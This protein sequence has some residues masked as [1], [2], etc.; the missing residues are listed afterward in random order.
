M[1]LLRVLPFTLLSC[2]PV[3]AADDPGSL[4]QFLENAGDLTVERRSGK[5]FIR[6]R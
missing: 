5:V 4:I 2:F 6:A 3:F 1:I